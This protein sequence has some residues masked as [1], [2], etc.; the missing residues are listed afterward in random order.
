MAKSKKQ[1]AINI[2]CT[3]VLIV[4][5]LGVVTD[6]LGEFTA[7]Q[8]L[9]NIAYFVVLLPACIGL[10]DWCERA[11]PEYYSN[12]ELRKKGL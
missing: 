7:R 8:Y 11:H 10:S 9:Y 4:A 6:F 1:R 2:V 12:D 3:I 5:G